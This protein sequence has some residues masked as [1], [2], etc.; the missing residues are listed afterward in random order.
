MRGTLH[1]V[2]ASDIRWL[3]EL[4]ERTLARSN[5]V[6]ADT[7]QG[8]EQLNRSELLAVLEQNSISTQ[9]QRAAYMLQRASLD[10]LICKGVTRRNIPT[11][12]SLDRSLPETGAMEHDEAV[13]ELGRRYFTSRSPA[14]ICCPVSTSTCSATGAAAPHLRR[15]TPKR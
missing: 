8:G 14:F 6:L 12:M 10:G 7:L 13:A 1:F 5:T 15:C 4:D 3:L 9:G 11:Y 2:A